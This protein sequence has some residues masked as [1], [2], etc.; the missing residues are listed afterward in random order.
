MNELVTEF[1]SIS[2]VLFKNSSNSEAHGF[3]KQITYFKTKII[4]IPFSLFYLMCQS[5]SGLKVV[6]LIPSPAIC[7]LLNS[8]G[9]HFFDQMWQNF[10]S[11][12]MP[13]LI[14]KSGF[15]SKYFLCVH[16]I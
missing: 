7:T 11:R 3:K 8:S 15:K 12:M 14:K 10:I 5:P 6:D 16:C 4:T 2:I 9:L 13:S 1:F